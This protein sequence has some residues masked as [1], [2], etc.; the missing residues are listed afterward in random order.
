MEHIAVYY[1]SD[2]NEGSEEDAAIEDQSNIAPTLLLETGQY[3]RTADVKATNAPINSKPM[4]CSKSSKLNFFGLVKDREKESEHQVDNVGVISGCVNIQGCQIQIPEGDFW[5]QFSQSDITNEC[6]ENK[7]PHK[8]KYSYLLPEQPSSEFS[9]AKIINVPKINVPLNKTCSEVGV[10][11]SQSFLNRQS[12]VE[13]E[14]GTDKVY[15]VHPKVAPYLHLKQANRY[16]LK[17]VREWA[18]HEGAVNRIA[19]CSAQ[20]FSHLLLSAS[21][22]TTVNVWSVWAQQQPCVRALSVHSK[23]VRDAVWSE[24]GHSILSS[25][26]DRTAAISDVQTGILCK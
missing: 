9:G 22:D 3:E 15:T 2:S 26:Y 11:H 5:Q 8:R 20:A 12:S 1:S 7:Y 25:S 13:R 23:A 18:G 10:V 24:D 16:P 17:L 6:L 4:N 21:M 19:W 14:P